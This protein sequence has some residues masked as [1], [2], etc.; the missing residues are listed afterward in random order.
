MAEYREFFF[1]VCV[2]ALLEFYTWIYILIRIK[3]KSEA[4]YTLG[5]Y[6]SPKGNE[7]KWILYFEESENVK[8]RIC[9]W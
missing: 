9:E 7:W 3:R 6:L 2:L 8:S 5:N 4:I 1:G